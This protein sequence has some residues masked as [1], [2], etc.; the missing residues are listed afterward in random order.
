MISDVCPGHEQEGQE[1]VCNVYLI[2]KYLDDTF[3]LAY[4]KIQVK[5]INFGAHIAHPS[6]GAYKIK[7]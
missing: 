2:I 1:H 7:L 4:A 5:A 6:A 3:L